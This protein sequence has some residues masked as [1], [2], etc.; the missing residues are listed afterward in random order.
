MKN[1]HKMFIELTPVLV[2]IDEFHQ[3]KVVGSLSE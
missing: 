2:N 3:L 1:T